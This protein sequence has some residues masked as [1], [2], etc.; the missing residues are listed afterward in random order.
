MINTQAEWKNG[1]LW[2]E[3]GRDWRGVE[4]LIKWCSE[5]LVISSLHW[6]VDIRVLFYIVTRHDTHLRSLQPYVCVVHDKTVCQ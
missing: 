2:R 3:E 1:Y 4:E 6:T 5:V